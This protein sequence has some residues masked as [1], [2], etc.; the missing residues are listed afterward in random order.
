[1][2]DFYKKKFLPLYL[3]L[4]FSLSLSLSL[5]CIFIPTFFSLSLSLLLS[6]YITFSRSLSLSKTTREMIYPEMTQ[7]LYW[8]FTISNIETFIKPGP[9]VP[10]PTLATGRWKIN[11]T[12]IDKFCKVTLNFLV[13]KIHIRRPDIWPI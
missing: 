2:K 10:M 12:T 5:P 11:S 3:F 4:S 1:M 13:I 8:R 6:F 7:L 9:A